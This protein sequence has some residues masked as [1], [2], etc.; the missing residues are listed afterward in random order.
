[1]DR[2][3][4]VYCN[5]GYTF[6]DVEFSYDKRNRALGKYTTYRV[7]YISEDEETKEQT[8]HT[9][10]DESRDMYINFRKF[11]SIQEMKAHDVDIIKQNLGRDMTD[12]AGYTFIY[13]AEP[14]QRRYFI[15]M[16]H[17]HEKI[18]VANISFDI[19]KNI[20]ELRFLSAKGFKW[21][22]ETT[23]DC[24][25]TNMDLISKIMFWDRWGQ[26]VD[27]QGYDLHKVDTW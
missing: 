25:E 23:S 22:F 5:A 20:K 17:T 27:L 13:E 4:K 19:E 26:Q 9:R 16:D 21:D 15:G 3:L 8:I 10:E 1:M 18:G 14:V 12:P 11:S 6:A 7:L 24:L 2:V